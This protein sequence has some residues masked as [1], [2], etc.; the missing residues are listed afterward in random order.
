MENMDIVNKLYQYLINIGFKDVTN[1]AIKYLEASNLKVYKNVLDR[2]NDSK[3]YYILERNNQIGI[4]SRWYVTQSE[5]KILQKIYNKDVKEIRRL[6]TEEEDHI[7]CS[8][9]NDKI[10]FDLQKITMEMLNNK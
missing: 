1:T 7:Y 10:D 3:Y 9:A 2:I 4:Q 6:L 8:I 5:F